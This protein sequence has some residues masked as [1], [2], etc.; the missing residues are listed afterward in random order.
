MMDGSTQ[1]FVDP[2]GDIVPQDLPYGATLT[3]HPDGNLYAVDA[4]PDGTFAIAQVTTQG[5]FTN[6]G[7]PGTTQPQWIAAGSDGYIWMIRSPGSDHEVIAKISPQGTG[8][9][10]Y[11]HGSFLDNLAFLTSG[12]DGNLWALNHQSDGDW[13]LVRISVADGS[14]E[15]MPGGSTPFAASFVQMPDGGL[16]EANCH[17]YLTRFDTNGNGQQYA[18]TYNGRSVTACFVAAGPTSQLYWAGQTHVLGF[19]VFKHTVQRYGAL[20]GAASDRSTLVGPDQNFWTKLC[21]FNGVERLGIDLL[22]LIVAKPSSVTVHAGSS[23]SLSVS[24]KRGPNQTFTAVSNNPAIATV[25]GS[26]TSFTVT[27]V[28]S[29]STTVTVSDQ[30]GNSLDVP[31]KVQ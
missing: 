16:W 30:I 26:G 23:T 3:T 29:G 7:L 1:T 10:E 5:T 27:G 12:P 6:Y 15:E 21:C 9:T 2:E 31:V 18:L 19:N 24:E 8:Y 13:A 14:I 4:L 25:S 22:H 20:P 17:T 28:S 11:P